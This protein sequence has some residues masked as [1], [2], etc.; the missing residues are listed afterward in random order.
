MIGA[1]KLERYVMGRTLASVG[2]AL[3]PAHGNDQA[4]LLAQA[5][6]AMYQAKHGGKNRFCWAQ[7]PSN[8]D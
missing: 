2:A 8:A 5:D 4:Q 3:Y 1:G 7:P 6:S